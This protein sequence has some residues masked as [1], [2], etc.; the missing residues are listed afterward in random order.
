MNDRAGPMGL[1]DTQFIKVTEWLWLAFALVII[2]MLIAMRCAMGN[3]REKA[4]RSRTQQYT[5]RPNQVY[6]N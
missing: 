2:M 6:V 5:Y 1:I 3:I 4:R